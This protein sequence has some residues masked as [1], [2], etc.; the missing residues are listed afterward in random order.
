ME[1]PSFS[2]KSGFYMKIMISHQS[3]LQRKILNPINILLIHRQ[4]TKMVIETLL[5]VV[6]IEGFEGSILV[7]SLFLHEFS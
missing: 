3:Q 1:I 2:Q 4:I 5:F 6:E 7:K